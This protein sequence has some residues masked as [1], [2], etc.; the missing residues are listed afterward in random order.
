MVF[1][2][3]NTVVEKETVVAEVPKARAKRKP[4][5]APRTKLDVVPID[6]FHQRWINDEPGRIQQAQDS[7]YTFVTPQES[8]REA[9]QDNK[10]KVLAGR[11]RDDITPMYTYLMK[12]PM[13]YYLED[14]AIYEGRNKQ[15]EDAIRGGKMDRES[16]DG[17]Y[18]PREG[19]SLK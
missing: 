8:N 4:F 9:T 17:R 10:V 3:K 7:G 13:E 12:I 15:I 6:G 1:Q 14:K 19:I 16:G 11:Q 18:I 5:G 2:K